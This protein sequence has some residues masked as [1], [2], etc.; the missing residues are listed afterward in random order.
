MKEIH[1]CNTMQVTSVPIKTSQLK[2]GT[3][4]NN[5]WS[6]VMY[7]TINAWPKDFDPELPPSYRVNQE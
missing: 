5:V 4:K 1:K 2:L 7:C 3:Q 6:K